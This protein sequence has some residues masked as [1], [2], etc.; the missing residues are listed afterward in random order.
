MKTLLVFLSLLY[1]TSSIS[2]GLAS[3]R[4]QIRVVGS[5]TVYPF[6][7]SVA[8]R[9]GKSTKYKTPVIEST[10][11]G[12]GIKIFCSGMDL[13]YADVTNAS[14]RMKKKEFDMCVKNGVRNILEVKV[15]YDGV[16]LANSKNS[17]RYSMTL[18]DVY[19][20]LAKNI[21][22]EDGKIIPNPY[23]T[24]KEINPMLPSNNIEV[25]GPP[26][27]SGTRDAFVELA[28][29]GGCK[30]FKWVKALKKKDKPAY[31]ELCHT[32]REDGAYIEAG[33]NDNM[34]LHKL[35]VNKNMLGIFGFSF[36]DMNG[37]KV[38]GS[39]IQ[40]K[41][42]TFDNISQRTYPISRPL[43]FYVKKNNIGHIKGLKE[44]V[45]LF[46]SE[47]SSGPDG[48]LTDQGLISLGQSERKK[49][50]K[51]V[52]NMKNLNIR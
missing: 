22:T 48:F 50:A 35:T 45:K 30:K 32:I 52:L 39:I 43:Y 49:R 11:S 8:E 46:I 47:K 51:N 36:L 23:K 40:G 21:P 15:G 16:V 33:E 27:T 31:K 38:Q 42:P 7:T 12:G 14:R 37:N 20:A 26:P 6:A 18:K 28:M 5:S 34:I 4:E 24:W 19:L 44:Y 2:V 3:D 9:F 13:K 29:E 41:K 1:V 10:G 17:K 25:M